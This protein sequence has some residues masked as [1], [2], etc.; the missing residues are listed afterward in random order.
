MTYTPG[1]KQLKPGTMTK[2][3]PREFAGAAADYTI[4]VMLAVP[5]DGPSSFH[6]GGGGLT[7]EY[8]NN[9]FLEPPAIITRVDPAV[10]FDWLGSGGGGAAAAALPVTPMK[11]DGVSVR[12][13]GLLKVPIAE[14]Y[15]FTL[16]ANDGARLYIDEA[17]VVV[18]ET[19]FFAKKQQEQQQQAAYGGGRSGSVRFETAGA[20]HR[21][22]V[23]MQDRSGRAAV[24]LFWQSDRTPKQLVPSFFLYPAAEHISGSPLPLTVFAE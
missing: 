22:R 9:A 6:G 23:D 14:E 13:T 1:K 3:Q 11:T 21:I 19:D 24:R 16:D 15:T 17:L 10:N 4:D 2:V 5:F 7:G 12:W 20:L 18:T 8:F